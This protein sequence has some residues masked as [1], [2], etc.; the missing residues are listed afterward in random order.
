MHI[1]ITDISKLKAALI[2]AAKKDIR[3]YLNG[4]LV[5]VQNDQILLVSTDGHRLS[6]IRSTFDADQDHK[7]IGHKFIIPREMIER[8]LKA[9]GK[10]VLTSIHFEPSVKNGVEGYE[11]SIQDHLGSLVIDGRAIDGK[12]PYW[13]KVY[14][15]RSEIPLEVRVFSANSS[16]IAEF[17]KIA[18][19]L[20]SRK[21]S[22]HVQF[23][24]ISP[25]RYRVD[26]GHKDFSGI[27][28]G[29]RDTEFTD[30]SWVK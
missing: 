28:M 5:E 8:Y 6:I 18:K 16:Y 14:S 29:I 12:F 11:I 27:L 26:I 24:E 10:G 15:T 23:L 19:I 21:D 17:G 13:R 2:F 3:Y 20:G 9:A 25:G 22:V 30:T 4:V 7:A 1:T